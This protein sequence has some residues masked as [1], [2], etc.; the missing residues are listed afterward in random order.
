MSSS[1]LAVSFGELLVAPWVDDDL[2]DR[3]SPRSPEAEHLWLP[4]IGPTTY[5][6][7]VRLALAAE[8][9]ALEGAG[10]TVVDVAT[11]ATALGVGQTLA[12]NSPMMRSFDRLRVFGLARTAKDG[13][14]FE[15]R[16]L[17]PRPRPAKGRRS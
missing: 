2:V 15:I 7:G 14:T 6:L 5:L 8:A 4:R 16:T 9:A 3:Y 1:T 13:W 12:A 10:Y 11:L 17:W